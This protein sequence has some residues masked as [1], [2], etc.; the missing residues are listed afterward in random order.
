MVYSTRSTRGT[1]VSYITSRTNYS[2]LAVWK[3]ILYYFLAEYLVNLGCLIGI[4]QDTQTS[5]L[6]SSASTVPIPQ[7]LEILDRKT[8]NYQ[9]I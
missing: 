5:K 7:N 9:S 3:I 1:L 6:A 4:M 8:I 2:Q